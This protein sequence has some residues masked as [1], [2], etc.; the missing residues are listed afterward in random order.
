MNKL[1][2]KEVTELDNTASLMRGKNRE[3]ES[4]LWGSD[5]RTSLL[6]LVGNSS[7]L[8]KAFSDPAV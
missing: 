5:Y 7:L 1:N 2:S 8:R 3:S 6:L 4:D